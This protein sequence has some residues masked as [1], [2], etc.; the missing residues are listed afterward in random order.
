MKYNWDL[1]KIFKDEKEIEDAYSELFTLLD[2]LETYKG[3]V[4]KSASNL[5]RVLYLDERIDYLSE[6]IYVYSNLAYYSDMANSKYRELTSRADNMLNKLRDVTS[7]LT[8]ELMESDFE[9]VKKIISEDSSLEKYTHSLERIYRYK[10][11]TLSKEEERILSNVA[12]SLD[13]C[14]DAFSQLDNTDLNLGYMKDENGKRV[15]LTNHNFTTMLSSK[16]ERVRKTAFK[17]MYNYFKEHINTISSLYLGNIKADCFYAKTKK[18]KNSLVAHLYPDN[19]NEELYKNLIKVTNN[20]V[21]SLQKYYKTKGKSIN[22]KLHMYDMYLNTSTLIE[23]KIPY[24]EGVKIC[25]KAL[26]VLGEYYLEKFNYIINNRSVDVYPKDNKRSGAYQ[27]GVY[28]IDPYVSLNYEENI[29]SVS[30]LIHEMGHAMHSY[31]SDT[32][33]DYIYA[34]YS[35]FLAEIA[36]TVNEILLSNYLIKNC[37]TKEE[38]IY[39]LVE[40]LDKFKATV[41]RQ[42]MFAEFEYLAHKD[43][44]EG[45][46]ITKDY[47]CNL[48]YDLNKKQFGNS[49]VVDKEIQYEWAR[50]PHFYTSFYVY[51]YATGFI[52]ALVIADKLTNEKD[53]KDKYIKFLSSGNTKYPLELLKEL[54]IDLCDEK[55]LDKAFKLFD[56]KVD[57]L[58]KLVSE[59]E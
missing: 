12:D 40:F 21:K 18:Y 22:K 17:K 26:D 14:E 55:T 56:E 39:Y 47:L 38:K 16:N 6:K 19:V 7:F 51:K 44:E 33:Q 5:S 3:K 50:I 10:E 8:P 34:G 41:F 59:N 20:N 27:W 43:F 58:N 28:A 36:S 15:K 29:D 23:E 25:N 49:L 11:H 45:K 24:E 46:A 32:N 54:D 57:E 1:T 13:S 42:V 31:L 2:E 52:S 37:K 9:S 35:I 30:T 48:Y 53:F 4:L